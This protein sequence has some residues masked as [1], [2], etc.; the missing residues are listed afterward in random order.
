MLFK[1]RRFSGVLWQLCNRKM[2]TL[3][4]ISICNTQFCHLC[5]L[6]D[7]MN[8]GMQQRIEHKLCIVVHTF[9]KFR[10]CNLL[11][12][13]LF[14]RIVGCNK[15]KNHFQ[16][17]G[18]KIN[19]PTLPRPTNYLAIYCTNKTSAFLLPVVATSNNTALL[20]VRQ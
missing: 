19:I 12:L 14:V 1:Q 4:D 8:C 13:E 15:F 11:L 6:P 2:V 5:H 9:V 10:N 16:L 3:S 20:T 7:T 18:E 17:F